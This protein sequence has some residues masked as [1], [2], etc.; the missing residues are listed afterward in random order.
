MININMANNFNLTR[1]F[2]RSPQVAS[3]AFGVDK[4]GQ[5]LSAVPRFKFDFFVEFVLSATGT[6]MTSNAQLNTYTGNRGLSF[7]VKSIDKPKN[8]LTSTELNQYNKRKIVYSKIEYQDTTIKLFDTV[9][10][11]MLS[12]WVDYFTYY[13]A[14]SR[15]KTDNDYQQSPINSSFSDSSGWGFRPLSEE[16]NFFTKITVYALFANTYTAFSYINPKI[17]TIDWEQKDS[18]ASEFEELSVTFK[19]EAIQYQTFAQPISNK[20]NGYEFFGWMASDEIDSVFSQNLP[21][22][23][24]SQPKLFTGNTS[25]STSTVSQTTSVG[26]QPVTLTSFPNIVGS[27]P[28]A[29]SDAVT[30]FSQLNTPTTSV[31][32]GTFGS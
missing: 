6:T 23:S 24:V 22:W 28:N 16:T 9:D 3:R 20:P 2:Q 1:V 25:G 29:L 19:Y 5:Y 11:S 13:F 18:S 4:P 21:I 26:N 8:N 32:N 27:T 15:Q 7:K 10:D 12:T 17:T 31:I 14:D 30:I